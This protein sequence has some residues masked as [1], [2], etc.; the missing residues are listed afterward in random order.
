MRR[1]GQI[2][3]GSIKQLDEGVQLEREARESFE[4]I[5]EIP[6][7]RCLDASKLYSF[8]A[9]KTIMPRMLCQQLVY[10]QSQ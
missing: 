10:T 1:E 2:Y 7:S 5:Y 6:L 8:M 3:V 4:K 9:Y